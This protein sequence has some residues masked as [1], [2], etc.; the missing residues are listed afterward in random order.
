[1]VLKNLLGIIFAGIL[2]LSAC[3]P[4]ADPMQPP[5]TATPLPRAQ[6]MT[7]PPLPVSTPFRVPAEGEPRPRPAFTPFR[8]PEAPPPEMDW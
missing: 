5:P 3:K 4:A 1:M 7:P 8:V 6:R 2:L